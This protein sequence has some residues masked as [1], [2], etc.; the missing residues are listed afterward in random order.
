MSRTRTGLFAL[1]LGLVMLA[2]TVAPASAARHHGRAPVKFGADLTT[3]TQPSNSSP[4]HTCQH[5]DSN[6][7]ANSCTRVILS[8]EIGSPNN[9]LTAPSTGTVTKIRLIAGHAGQLT[10]YVAFLHNASPSGGQAK[11]TAH[12]TVIHYVSSVT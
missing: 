4:P 12:S 2:F 9:Q 6:L 7:T 1:G 3:H 10:A 5:D 8:S 11:V